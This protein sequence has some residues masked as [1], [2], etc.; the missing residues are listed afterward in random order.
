MAWE[1]EYTD[2]F[3]VN[4]PIADRLYDEYLE[5]LDHEGDS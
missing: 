4:V 1:I 5:E 3:K 2:E